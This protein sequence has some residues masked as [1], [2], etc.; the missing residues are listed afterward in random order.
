MDERKLGATG[1]FPDGKIHEDDEGAI[2]ISVGD[3]KGNVIIDFGSPVV[4]LGI[5]PDDARALAENISERADKVEG[6]VKVSD[7]KRLVD[8]QA[9]MGCIKQRV[10]RFEKEE[11]LEGRHSLRVL[12]SDLKRMLGVGGE[13]L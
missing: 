8:T 13:H 1:E 6:Y 11:P 10:L 3:A 5:P 4:W 2:R 7:A 12:I 9:V